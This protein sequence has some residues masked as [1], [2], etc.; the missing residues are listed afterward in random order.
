[1]P[2]PRSICFL[3]H[4][5][6]PAENS[7]A[8]LLGNAAFGLGWETWIGVV[9]SLALSPSGMRCRGV[10]LSGPLGAGVRPDEETAPD[11][12]P[13]DTAG[14]IWTQSLGRRSSFLDVVELLW[15]LERNVPFVNSVNA[16]MFLNNK[17]I[18]AGYLDD[19][20]SPPSFISNDPDFLADAVD[21]SGQRDWI[22]KPPAESQGRGVLKISQ[23][24]ANA[25]PLLEWTTGMA[26][27]RHVIVQENVATDATREKRVLMADERVV[28]AYEKRPAPGGHRAN[29][30][31]G[32]V[33][34]PTEL[35]KE[36]ADLCERTARWCKRHGARF[37]GID[38]ILP[39]VL[40]VNVVNPG[41][42]GT[43]KTLGGPDLS[44]SVI[45]TLMGDPPWG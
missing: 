33:A 8:A 19:V 30:H 2:S 25:K 15:L 7:N 1:M 18:A 16:L 12:L 38:L 11:V 39:Y 26:S 42:L 37:I 36:E 32:G 17:Y 44:A 3:T 40:E 4:H 9:D 6:S 31:Q 43:L 21:G 10:R 45:R 14:V 28:L 13:V 34:S 20:S 41:G 24:D 29:L 23:G 5:L 35:T 22:L 27:K